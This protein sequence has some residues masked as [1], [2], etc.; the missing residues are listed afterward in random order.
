MPSDKTPATIER[1]IKIAVAAMGGQGGGVL[2]DW[3]VNIA[4][5]DNYYAQCTSVPGVAQRTGATVYYLEVFPGAE[6]KESSAPVMALMPVPGDVDLVIAGEL[7]EAGR[8]VLRGLVTKDRTTLVTSTHRDYALTEKMAMAD[9][10]VNSD[11]VIA[12]AAAAAQT[13]IAFDMAALAEETGSV[14]SAILLGAAAGSGAL[15]FERADFEDAV[16]RSGVAVEANLAGFAAGYDHARNKLE[17]PEKAAAS[18]GAA[19]PAIHPKVAALLERVRTE[20][21]APSHE[22]LTNG[23][24]RLMDFQDPAYAADYLDRLR[25]VQEIDRQNGSDNH[26][27][28]ETGRHLALWMSFEDTIRVADLKTRASRFDR[29][30][31]EVRAKPDQIVD[32]TEFMHPR[33]QEVCDTLPAGL[34]RWVLNSPGLIKMLGYLCRRGR[35]VRTTSLSGFLLLYAIASLRRLRRHTLRYQNETREISSWLDRVRSLARTD[36]ALALEWVACQGL[37]KGYGDTHERGI[38]SYRSILSS[39]EDIQRGAD[40]AATLRRLREAA[41]ADENGEALRDNLGRVA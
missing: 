16:R 20:F 38:H 23:V 25:P 27:T 28:T 24:R 40:P 41:L 5:H 15:P 30:R 36:Y 19:A 17:T 13:F 33:V 14:I 37:V 11:K 7:M 26:L 4:E 2:S 21:E 12:A 39:L 1:P 18:A 9:G 22:V 29:C 32:I 31:Q 3:I 35:R 6:N 10:R 8:A 34:G